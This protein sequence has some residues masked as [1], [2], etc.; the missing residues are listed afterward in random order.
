MRIIQRWPKAVMNKMTSYLFPSPKDIMN[1]KHLK[2]AIE[3]AETK[4]ASGENGPFGAVVVKNNIIVGEGWNQV[5]EL[6][7]PTAHAEIMAIRKA[8]NNLS[9][10]SLEGCEL[11]SSCEPCPMCL[12]AIYWARI[13]VLFFA[14]NSEDA[15]KTGFD[16]SFIYRQLSLNWE[17][18][19]I[20]TK[21]ECRFE[22]IKVFEKWMANP[23]R[24]TY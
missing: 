5:I 18:R 7:D 14:C 4:S 1:K 24:I 11:Y 12:S 15:A 13:G 6:N 20:M 16:D 8:C 23:N 21:Q 22:G 3:L 2:K 10:F 19:A 9:L 17:E